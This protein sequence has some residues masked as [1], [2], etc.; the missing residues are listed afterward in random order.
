MPT[1][2]HRF[3]PPTC[4]LEIKETK[5]LISRWM[6]KNLLKDFKFELTF[7]D[8]RLSNEKQITITGDRLELEQLKAAVDK[9][10]QEKLYNCFLD[11]KNLSP[12]GDLDRDRPYLISQGL[13]NCELFFGNLSH[14]SDRDK[15]ILNTVRLFDLV[16]VLEAYESQTEALPELKQKQER[17]IIPLWGG[18]AAVAL[19]AIGVTAVLLQS[20]PVQNVASS[21]QSESSETAPQF[22]DV[23]P[24]ETPP[25]SSQKKPQL[26]TDKSITA[27]KRLP[28][29]PAVSTPK[30][31]PNILDPADYPMSQVARQSGLK[32]PEKGGTAGEQIES[33]ISV[34]PK[35]ISE[36]EPIKPQTMRNIEPKKV[37]SPELNL[38]E[39]KSDIALEN[40]TIK[41][42]LERELKAY[43]QEKWQPPV[44]LKQSLEYRLYLNPNGSIQKVVPIG[45]ASELYLDRTNIPVNGEI[46]VS[47]STESQ[48]VR[49]LLNPDGGI[50]TLIE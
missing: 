25:T 14:N 47:P 41:P 7:D 24:P 38:A 5:S 39:S 30:P 3:T 12:R 40:S 33:T 48:I 1:I 11:Y 28:P 8:P 44:N 26:K 46:F 43:F 17:E 35:A 50:K 10:T 18:I 42:N 34:S 36:V 21:P 4:T 2:L 6:N 49:L 31:K 45:K 15:M 13:T 27:A 32:Q 20:S 19:T 37:R 9:Y 16:T 23:V 22:D 29:P